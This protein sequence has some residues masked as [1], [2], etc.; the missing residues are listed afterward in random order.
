[1]VK[2]FKDVQ[3]FCSPGIIKLYKLISMSNFFYT[4]HLR[5]WYLVQKTLLNLQ[6]TRFSSAGSA[7]AVILENGSTSNSI[8]NILYMLG[9]VCAK[10]GTFVKKCTMDL[11][12]S[13]T[14]RNV[15]LVGTTLDPQSKIWKKIQMVKQKFRLISWLAELT[16][17]TKFTVEMRLVANIFGW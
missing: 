1:M 11:N 5:W 13:P 15:K 6:K 16:R 8:G 7:V 17:E 4:Q 12:I 14:Y 10:F 9:Y 2:N 3:V